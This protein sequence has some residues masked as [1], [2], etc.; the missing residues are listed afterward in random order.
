MFR[1]LQLRFSILVSA[2]LLRGVVLNVSL[3]SLRFRLHTINLC[4]FI[5]SVL[6]AQVKPR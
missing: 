3:L 2:P 1:V 4:L 6:T 5:E